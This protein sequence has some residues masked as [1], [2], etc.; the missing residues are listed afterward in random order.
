MGP[1]QKILGAF[2]ES[3]GLGTINAEIVE[4]APASSRGDS[5]VDPDS[6]RLRSQL[7][8]GEVDLMKGFHGGS[9]G[10]GSGWKM[11]LIGETFDTRY[12]RW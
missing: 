10:I 6:P 9:E 8:D 12:G 1:P 5:A 7:G 4:A 11:P 2:V 3:F